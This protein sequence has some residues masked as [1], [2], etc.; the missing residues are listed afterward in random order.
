MHVFRFL[1]SVVVF[2]S[3]Q[4]V[5][6]DSAFAAVLLSGNCQGL[7]A[8]NVTFN[9]DHGQV[10]FTSTL[11]Q[12]WASGGTLELFL[13]AEHKPIPFTLGT[14]TAGSWPIEQFLG[15]IP[16][17]NPA[18]PLC[19][20]VGIDP[21]FQLPIYADGTRFTGSSTA[22]GGLE[23]HLLANGGTLY[24]HISGTTN[25]LQETT[26][27]ATLQK[28]VALSTDHLTTTFSGA[29]EV[30]PNVSAYHGTATFGLTGNCLSYSFALDVSFP[31]FSVGIYGPAGA[32][33][34]STNLVSDFGALLGVFI[35]PGLPGFTGQIIY[36]GQISLSD[37]QV[38]QLERGKLY[39][40]F[41]TAQY[42]NGEIRGQI[43][44]VKTHGHAARAANN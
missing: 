35:P 42:P 39:V 25:A 28:V 29:N 19:G 8:G 30:P 5:R 41:L 4:R 14:G 15:P 12:Q 36:S 1:L 11:F 32:R 37:E 26:F 40:N 18:P 16:C 3:A 6:A 43:L 2:A 31:A 9:V 23:H 24:L 33:S 10:S 44:P 13:V 20:F 17:V 7:V 21:G 34:N 22:F 38:D 27:S